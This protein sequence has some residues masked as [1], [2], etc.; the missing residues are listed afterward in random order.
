MAAAWAVEPLP[1]L[2]ELRGMLGEPHPVHHLGEDEHPQVSGRMRPAGSIGHHLLGRMSKELAAIPSRSAGPPNRTAARSAKISLC[3]RPKML[4][5]PRR[6]RAAS[7][8]PLEHG[9]AILAP[10]D[11][12]RP[13]GCGRPHEGTRPARVGHGPKGC[14]SRETDCA[15]RGA[16]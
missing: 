5:H 13:G 15:R 11:Q 2:G 14:E 4:I 1:D 16:G 10:R 9:I 12:D 7:A 3:H 8:Q 6:R